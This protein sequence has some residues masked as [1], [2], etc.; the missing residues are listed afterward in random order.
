MDLLTMEV[1]AIVLLRLHQESMGEP[2]M[3][4]LHADTASAFV[5]TDEVKFFYEPIISIKF[6]YIIEKSK[7]ANIY[8]FLKLNCK[9][10][11]CCNLRRWVSNSRIS[12]ALK[13]GGGQKQARRS[14]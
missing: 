5:K 12:G 2:G 14:F 6:Q 4:Q 11:T 10:L 9:Q 8:R 3:Q 1:V 13:I 7:L